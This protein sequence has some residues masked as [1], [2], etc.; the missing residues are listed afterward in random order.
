MFQLCRFGGHVVQL[1]FDL[2]LRCQAGDPQYTLRRFF[3]SEFRLIPIIPFCSSFF[4]DVKLGILVARYLAQTVRI[5][6]T[7]KEYVSLI[8]SIPG[9]C[10]CAN[11]SCSYLRIRAATASRQAAEK[12]AVNLNQ[13]AEANQELDLGFV[14][15]FSFFLFIFFYFLFFSIFFFL[16]S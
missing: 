3:I 11:I 5:V 15:F 2:L 9:F 8:P 4:A 13:G 6:V 14:L 10:G 16:F 7:L 12:I 1:C